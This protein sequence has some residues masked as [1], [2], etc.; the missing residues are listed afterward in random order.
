MRRG[1]V[2]YIRKANA[3]PRDISGGGHRGRDGI[4]SEAIERDDLGAHEVAKGI[5][6]PHSHPALQGKFGRGGMHNL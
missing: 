2:F 1:V 4:G 5:A 6:H 3:K